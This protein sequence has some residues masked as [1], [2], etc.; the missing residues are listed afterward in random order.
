MPGG[1]RS[2]RGHR[3]PGTDA[4][5]GSGGKSRKF[6][7][8]LPPHAAGI[9]GTDRIDLPATQRANGRI[10]S[11]KTTTRIVRQQQWQQQWQQRRQRRRR[12]RRQSLDAARG[13]DEFRHRARAGGF[14]AGDPRVPRAPPEHRKVGGSA[15]KTGQVLDVETVRPHDARQDAGGSE[16]EG[17]GPS[18]R[19][20]HA[21]RIA[22]S[23]GLRAG[24][25]GRI[26]RVD[27]SQTVA[28]KNRTVP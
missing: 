20:R 24:P 17:T 1:G 19:A 23:P 16:A 28:A 26:I 3:R 27:K 2:P 4:H 18:T 8:N 5:P 21:G 6:Q 7:G 11:D 12:R 9:A 25:D 22:D 10:D 14:V 13:E 15:S